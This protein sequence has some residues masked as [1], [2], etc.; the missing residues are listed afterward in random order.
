RMK[1]IVSYDGT[2]NDTDALALGSLLAGAGGSLSLAYVRHA[3][4]ADA[5]REHQAQTDAAALLETGAAGAGGPG[6]APPRRRQRLHAGGAPRPRGAGGRR[7]RRLR[8][9]VPDDPRVRPAGN[10]GAPPARG[11]ADRARARAGR[12]VGRRVPRDRERRGCGR[13]RRPGST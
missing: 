11:W 2:K 1:I 3:K 9:G 5:T 8:L 10:V 4:E 6:G 7:D 13:G 12:A